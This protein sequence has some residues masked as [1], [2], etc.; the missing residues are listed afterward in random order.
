MDYNVAFI[1]QGCWQ[2]WWCW[3]WWLQ[4]L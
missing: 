2:W 4:W 3:W 1:R